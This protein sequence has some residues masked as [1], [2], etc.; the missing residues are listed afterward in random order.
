MAR[1]T[2]AT[3]V[4]VCVCVCL[5]VCVASKRNK[6]DLWLREFNL[7][8]RASPHLNFNQM[9]SQIKPARPHTQAGEPN[10]VTHLHF[11]RRWGPPEG[12]LC[13]LASSVCSAG[14]SW[15]GNDVQETSREAKTNKQSIF[16][17]IIIRLVNICL[18]VLLHRWRQIERQKRNTCC[19]SCSPSSSSSS[20][21]TLSDI[22]PSLLLSDWLHSFCCCCSFCSPRLLIFIFASL[23]RLTCPISRNI[24]QVEPKLN[25]SQAGCCSS[26]SSSLCS[27]LIK[28]N[29]SVFLLANVNV[30]A[31]FGAAERAKAKL[32]VVVVA[33]D[34]ER[35]DC[36]CNHDDHHQD[37]LRSSHCFF[38]V[39]RI[40]LNFDFHFPIF[41]SHFDFTFRFH[42]I[43][44]NKADKQTASTSQVNKL[45]YHNSRGTNMTTRLVESLNFWI[46]L[47]ELAG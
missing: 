8:S 35:D 7:K 1:V 10:C 19:F 25:Y 4:C 15:T 17:I 18:V 16:F 5:S 36:D 9:S 44:C 32:P 22:C 39:T 31:T 14:G 11:G 6:G 47:P 40:E 45:S 46:C 30:Q 42:S 24:R 3:S 23:A 38:L 21:L 34:G 28:T 13:E 37:D 43:E 12:H 20:Q 33:S 26:L 2:Q 29:R 41:V 27:L